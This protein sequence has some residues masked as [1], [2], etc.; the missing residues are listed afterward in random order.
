[1]K[2]VCIVFIVH[3]QFLCMMEQVEL[4]LKQ[5]FDMDVSVVIVDNGSEDGLDQWLCGQNFWNYVICDRPV[6]NYSQ[7]LNIMKEEFVSDRDLLVISPNIMIS[8]ELVKKCWR[9]YT[10]QRI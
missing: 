5:Q 4:L 7:I 8:N 3:N 10:G 1:M 2:K 6:G 9:Q